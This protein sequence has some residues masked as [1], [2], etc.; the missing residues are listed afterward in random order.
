MIDANEFWWGDYTET[1]AWSNLR[2]RAMEPRG[3]YE[4]IARMLG[5]APHAYMLS[6]TRMTPR[7]EERCIDICRMVGANAAWEMLD[8]FPERP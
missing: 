6:L 8:R 4:E 7:Q 2:G 1:P 3:A 5:Y